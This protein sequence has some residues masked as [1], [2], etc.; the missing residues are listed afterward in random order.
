MKQD[1][2]YPS[3]IDYS[4]LISPLTPRVGPLDGIG[5][6]FNL[7]GTYYNIDSNLED[8]CKASEHISGLSHVW[9]NIGTDIFKAADQFAELNNIDKISAFKYDLPKLSNNSWEYLLNPKKY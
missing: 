9:K 4:A 8:L 3:F 1:K 2:K 6:L 5:S 7:T